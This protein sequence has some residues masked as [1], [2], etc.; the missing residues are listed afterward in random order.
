MVLQKRSLLP[1]QTSRNI[2]PLLLR[3]H[4]PI[5]SLIKH[6]ILMKS[7]T[8]LRQ[9]L[10]LPPQRAKSPPINT[11]AMRSAHDVRP[12]FVDRRVDHVGGGVEQAVLAA[13]DDFAGVVDED[14]V[15]FGHEAEGA[16]EGVHPEAVGLHGVAERDVAG[17]AL[18]E[19][20][21]A[22]DAEGGGQAAFEVFTL[23]VLVGEGWGPGWWR[24]RW[25]VGSLVI[26]LSC[27]RLR[28]T[29]YEGKLIILPWA[30]FFLTPGSRGAVPSLTGT[31]L[32]SGA[33][34]VVSS[35]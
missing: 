20:V 8:I 5:K 6:M 30:M 13:A 32:P 15:G 34:P 17:D 26:G 27:F 28:K 22:E 4:N 33:V 35:E 29:T 14:E 25:L 16:A 24:G 21:F 11:V 23:F 19:A 2:L 10:Q 31:S 18:V 1:P 3:Q 9:S 12:G 7:A